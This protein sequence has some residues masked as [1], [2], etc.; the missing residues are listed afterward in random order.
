MKN[1]KSGLFWGIIFGGIAG[2]MNATQPGEITRYQLKEWGKT[3]ASDVQQLKFKQ[4]HLQTVIQQ[5]KDEA[6]PQVNEL[7]QEIQVDIKHF[8]E[9]NQPRIRRTINRVEQLKDSI[10]SIQVEES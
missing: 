2:L 7:V 9:N 4:E 5:I 1:F 6:I 3:V 10:A 8:M